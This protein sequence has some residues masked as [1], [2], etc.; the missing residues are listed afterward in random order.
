MFPHRVHK[1]SLHSSSRLQK[2][3]GFT[4]MQRQRHFWNDVTE[5]IVNIWNLPLPKHW[6]L[7]SLLQMTHY[8]TQQQ[9]DLKHQWKTP[10]AWNQQ[11]FNASSSILL[12][13]KHI[14][15]YLFFI[16]F[17]FAAMSSVPSG[18]CHATSCT[19]IWGGTDGGTT[20]SKRVI[21]CCGVLLNTNKH[22]RR[23]YNPAWVDKHAHL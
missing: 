6:N 3:A 20:G 12:T 19:C 21:G 5:D 1:S 11:H 4:T 9:T 13:E 17:L 23:F 18:W 16:I 10:S 2:A 8:Q 7:Q 22:I 14:L 15:L